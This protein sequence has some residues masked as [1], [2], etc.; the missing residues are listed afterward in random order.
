MSN[1]SSHQLYLFAQLPIG[2]KFRYETPDRGKV[3]WKSSNEG[4]HH[5]G[6]FYPVS[7]SVLVFPI[8]DDIAW[9]E[10]IKPEQ[11][12]DRDL[13]NESDWLDELEISQWDS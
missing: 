10:V 12:A 11:G 9:E 3:Y 8:A 2:Q 6:A 4:A 7:P 1:S 5:D 13:D